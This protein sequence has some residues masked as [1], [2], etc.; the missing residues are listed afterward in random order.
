MAHGIFVVAHGLA[1]ACR[2]VV[3]THGLSCSAVCGI[4][5]PPTRD[6]IHISCTGKQLSITE[7][8]EKSLPFHIVIIN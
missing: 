7:P 8:P 3:E 2:S 5:V 4:L 1:V 6:Q